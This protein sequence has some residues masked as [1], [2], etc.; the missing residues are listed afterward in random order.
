MGKALPVLMCAKKNCGIETP[1]IQS[2]MPDCKTT[3]CPSKCQCIESKCA[4][5]IN[6]C[7]A[8]ATCASGQAC[9]DAC[10]CGDTA[11]ITNC[12]KKD[13][14]PKALPLLI[15]AKTNCGLQAN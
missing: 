13:P 6:D 3:A 1:S 15:C 5:Q 12:A 10:A 9:A 8:D 7:L 4:P 11:C 2:A 14:S